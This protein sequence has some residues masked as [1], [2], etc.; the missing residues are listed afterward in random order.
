MLKNR[1]REEQ[2]N[3]TYVLF[4]QMIR[5][6]LFSPG[7]GEKHDMRRK[8]REIE[9]KYGERFKLPAAVERRDR[10]SHGI[11]RRRNL[12]YKNAI[13]VL[14]GDLAPEFER[15]IYGCILHDQP[16]D[17]DELKNALFEVLLETDLK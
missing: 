16:V 14:L 2:D 12:E 10:L 7:D 9:D 1:S 5:R 3:F 6:G 4:S 17:P 11:V 13:D 15:Y 8:M